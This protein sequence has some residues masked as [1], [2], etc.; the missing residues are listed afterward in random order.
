MV[1]FLEC[2]NKC[3]M[4]LVEIAEAAVLLYLNCQK[5]KLLLDACCHFVVAQH[6]LPYNSIIQLLFFLQMLVKAL[7][8]TLVS[9]HKIFS[10]SLLVLRLRVLGDQP[11]LFI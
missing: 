6:Q 8:S 11:Q 9:V 1:L 7:Q 5:T 2:K 3:L 10:T 4:A